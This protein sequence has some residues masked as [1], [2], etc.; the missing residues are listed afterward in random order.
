MVEELVA[1]GKIDDAEGKVLIDT[2]AEVSLIKRGA[3]AAPLRKP[4]VVLKGVTGRTLYNYG[5][6]QVSLLLKPGVYVP[7]DYVVC[8]LPRGY[9]AVL[10]ID[11]LKRC[12][13]DPERGTLN[14][15]GHE[16]WLNRLTKGESVPDPRRGTRT[17][18]QVGPAAPASTSRSE[19]E[20]Q[21]RFVYTCRT[22]TVPARS[23]KIIEVKT[24]RKGGE[25][26]AT[27]VVDAILEPISL[28]PQG[29]YIARTYTRVQRNRCHT[30]VVNVSE[31]E[32]TLPVNT[33]I[34]KLEEADNSVREEISTGPVKIRILA[35]SHG[36]G[37]C[38]LL[39]ERLPN[40]VDLQSQFLPNGKLKSVMAGLD[41]VLS[42]L[43]ARD[44]VIIM[45]GTNDVSKDAPFRFTLAQAFHRLPQSWKPQI[46]FIGIPDRFDV[47]LVTPL[48]EANKFLQSLTVRFSKSHCGSLSFI[49]TSGK[50]SKAEY[51]KFGLHLNQAGKISLVGMM[52]DVI[53]GPSKSKR[54]RMVGSI[55]KGGLKQKIAEKLTHLK[56]GE[57]AALGDLLLEYEDIFAYDESQP[58]GCT[59][60]VK[61]VINTGEAVPIYKKAYRVPFHQKPII[62][63]LI[64]DQLDQG[65]IVPSHSPWASPVVLVPKRSPDGTPK[66]RFCVDF[67]GVNS[68]TVPDVYPLPNITETLDS[69]GGCKLFTTLDLRSGYHQIAVDEDSQA[70]TAFNVPSGHYHYTRMPFGLNTA[71]ATFQR[72]MDSVLMGLKGERCLVYLDDIILY[73]RDMPSHLSSLREVLDRLKGVDLSVQLSKCKFAVEE[74]NYLGHFISKRGVE[75]DPSKV[76][77]VK[78]FPIPKSVK[79]VRSFLGLAGYYRRFIEGFATIGRPLFDLTKKGE[80]FSWSS[81][82]Q[83]AFESLKRKLL[84]APILV[85]PDFTKPFILATDAS[86]EAIG[87]V[88]SQVVDGE[89]HP[90]A[91][92]S[93]SL[94]QAE[95]NYSVTELEMLGLVWATKYFRCYL[96]GRQFKVITDHAAL[97][98]LL[99]LKDPSS[100]LVRWTLRLAE[101]NYTVEH[102]AGKRHTNADALS[103]N[104]NVVK[105]ADVLPVVDLELLRK[106][107]QCDAH[108]QDL[109]R[110]KNFKLSPEKILYRCSGGLKKIVVPVSLVQSIIR[111]HHDLPTAGHAAVAKT[112][113]RVQERFWWK[114]MEKDVIDYVRTCKSCCQRSNYGRTQAPLGEIFNEPQAPFEVVATDIVGPLPLS[115]SGNV[116]ILSVM[117]HFTR[118]CEFIPLPNQTSAQV[119]RAL[120]Q[121]VIT[122]FGV[123]KML[124][125]DQGGSFTAELIA[126]LCKFLHIRK[127]QTTGFHP[128][129]NG[130]LERV[131]ST[132][133]KMLSHFVNRHQTNWDELLPCVTMAYNSQEHES[134]G[135]SPYEL[136]FGRKM[137]AP[138][139][140]DLTITENMDI[141]DDHIETLRETLREAHEAAGQRKT[142]ARKRNETQYNKKA[143]VGLYQVGQSVLLH[144]PS[145]GRHRVKKLSK[146]WKGP[147]RIVEVLSPLNVV[148]RIRKKD[149]TVHVN[150]IKPILERVVEDPS[151]WAEV[152]EVDAPHRLVSEEKENQ[153]IEVQEELDSNESPAED[154]ELQGVASASSRPQRKRA[155]PKK[156]DDYVLDDYTC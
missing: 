104:V 108:C 142:E 75:P 83:E 58:L 38:E 56:E 26:V 137:V 63:Q 121:R 141:F 34:G 57:R 30:K 82:C 4:D 68:V 43:S 76:T 41:K 148:L 37:L 90:V 114:G 150:R 84:T 51:T 74:V 145:I 8:N 118:Y 127:I 85:Y 79:D 100:R 86:K 46:A 65:I 97:K 132:V 66:Y 44:L 112:L 48:A 50:F 109:K 42:S 15:E 62:D 64:K 87:A 103:R 122:K 102:K 32:V 154:M 93:R 39:K 88:L 60:A 49:E 140:S 124:I 21:E 156:L 1:I 101:F 111:L 107:Q 96:L 149:V 69:L 113:A 20:P 115:E 130:R 153:Q 80:E 143:K 126:Q 12:P 61:H 17:S 128:Q 147:Y 106:R 123:P 27:E 35:D 131:H 116:Y 6:Q 16:V 7:G 95:R 134:T 3:A 18:T 47:D 31:E 139:E 92:A 29:V 25:G 9:L 129:S 5:R 33:K 77:A 89:E 54:V 53:L 59:S 152:D 55:G 73:S 67:R 138:L 23:E 10:G 133:A 146:L 71:P 119:A 136:L 14:F 19:H 144:V 40:S 2:G 72:L 99:S 94:H 28:I 78:E 125:S 135:Y 52:R 45:G 117:D 98:W 105:R 151:E 120:V 155:A 22:F 11:I 36:R 24:N 70:K 91:Y 81:E 110:A 13:I